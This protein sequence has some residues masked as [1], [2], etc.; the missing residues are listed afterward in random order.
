MKA[1]IR[2]KVLERNPDAIE[3]TM[4]LVFKLEKAAASCGP[5]GLEDRVLGLLAQQ[6]EASR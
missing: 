2:Q 1:T 4:D 6:W 5:P 3:K